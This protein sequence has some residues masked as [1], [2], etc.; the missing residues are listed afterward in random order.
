MQIDLQANEQLIS[1]LHDAEYV[2]VIPAKG[3]GIDAFCAGAAMHL[4]LK[5]LD[6]KCMIMY[7]GAVPEG[8]KEIIKESDIISSL[9]QRQLTVA[10]D[11]SSEHDAKA[12]YEPN[13]GTLKVK[14]APV[15]KE[16]D[17]ISKVVSKLDVGF[18]FDT[19]VILGANELEDL[20]EVYYEIQEELA[21]STIINVSNSGKN[22]R[23]GSINVID[24]TSDSLCQL[25]LKKA[26]L[27]ELNIN[28]QVAQALLLGITSK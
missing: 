11:Y 12:W 2:A 28:T 5:A 17:P 13:G 4:M 10:I 23:F 9:S 14:L 24:S 15:S 8:C 7:P 22:V 26:P 3:A 25:I 27:W 21:K 6:K 20:S 18:D 16:Y 1:V 19:A